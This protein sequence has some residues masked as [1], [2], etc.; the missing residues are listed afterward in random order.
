M[1]KILISLLL[2]TLITGCSVKPQR[3]VV[4]ETE[5]VYVPIPEQYIKECSTTQ[6]PNKKEYLAIEDFSDKEVV[7]AKY[8]MTLHKD[9]HNCGKQVEAIKKFNTEQMELVNKRK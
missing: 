7:L 2:V 4:K 3:I 6:P 9:V 5:L 1:N 8:I